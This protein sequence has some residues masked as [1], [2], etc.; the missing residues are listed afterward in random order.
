MEFVVLAAFAAL[1][2][3]FVGVPRRAEAPG[4]EADDELRER[5]TRLLRELRDLDDD[6][7]EGRISAG[8][9]AEGR[10]ALAPELRA[11]TEE[12]RARGDEPR[13]VA[14]PRGDA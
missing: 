4:V 12:L 2:A 10:R 8:D 5:R 3:L 6:A 13:R 7:N 1:A 14:A 9:R 11:V